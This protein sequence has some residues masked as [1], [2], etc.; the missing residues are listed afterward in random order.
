RLGSLALAALLLL[1]LGTAARLFLGALAVL[2]LAAL[3]ILQGLQA[4]VALVVGERTQHDAGR[5]LPARTATL[6]RPAALRLSRARRRR[7]GRC[8]RLSRSRLVLAFATRPDNATLHLL[9]HDRLRAAVGEALA[10]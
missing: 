7:G 1:A 9:D 8:L 4:R 6:R 2:D 5:A 10:H 3:G